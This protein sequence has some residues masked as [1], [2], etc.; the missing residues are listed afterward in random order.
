MYLRLLPL[1]RQE[2]IAVQSTDSGVKQSW[3]QILHFPIA[4]VGDFR[5][6]IS[7]SNIQFVCGIETK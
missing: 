1:G 5:Q 6:S 4:W 2:I 7:P 3:Y